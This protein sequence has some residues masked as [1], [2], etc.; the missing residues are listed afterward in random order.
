MARTIHPTKEKLIETMISLM[1]ENALASILV[2][3]VLRESNISKGSLYHHFENFDDLVEAALIA[4]FAAGVDSSIYLVSE[5]VNGAKS[6]EEL[7]EKIVLVTSATQG[8]TRSKFR[9]ERARVIGLSVNS[10]KLL[11]S[12]EREQERLTTAMADIVREGQEKGWVSK[13]F[14]AK[15][16]AVFLQAYTL[17]RVIDDV[18]GKDQQIDSNDWNDVVNT[19]VK[20]LLTPS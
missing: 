8:R 18:A 10:S 4:R 1:E 12:L 7:L 15:T 20:A 13:T 17:G 9:L 5:A 14:D 11:E 16:I 2:D 6:S 19:A 3:D